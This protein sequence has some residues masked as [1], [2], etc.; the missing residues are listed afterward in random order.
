MVPN[1]ESNS[2]GWE[3]TITCSMEEEGH[4]RQVFWAIHEENKLVSD[5]YWFTFYTATSLQMEWITDLLRNQT[6]LNQNKTNWALFILPSIC[7]HQHVRQC[8][9][10]SGSV[11]EWEP[12]WAGVR[13]DVSGSVRK[14]VQKSKKSKKFRCHMRQVM[15]P[16]LLFHNFIIVNNSDNMQ[17]MQSRRSISRNMEVL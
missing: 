13:T 8:A 11:Q 6:T 3:C 5:L 1:S 10:L 2:G 16:L 4:Y 12:I 15:E 17:F 7:V 14:C 9:Y